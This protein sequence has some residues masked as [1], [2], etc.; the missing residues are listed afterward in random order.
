M[1]VDDGGGAGPNYWPNSFGGPAPDEKAMEP[2]FPVDGTAD[3]TPYGHDN[4]DFVQSG[5]LFSRVMTDQDRKNLIGNIVEHLAG[6]QKRIQLRQCALFYKAHPDYGTGVAKGLALPL[7]EV[8][9][10]AA[11][12]QEERAKATSA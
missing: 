6:A 7:A 11:M 4:D 12:S 5:A 3:R 2:P 9:K 1:R 8:K 10:L